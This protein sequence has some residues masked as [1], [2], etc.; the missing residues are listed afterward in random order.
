MF[1]QEIILTP[2]QCESIIDMNK[3]YTPSKVIRNSE[4]VVAL[5]RTSSES[6]VDT[7]EEIKSILLPKLSKYGVSDLPNSFNL[8]KYVG[9]E[10]KKHK[11]V[12]Y[13]PIQTND[14]KHY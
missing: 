2:S 5:G 14:I 4:V 1:N 6:K 12:G 11:D 7:S 8:L 3:G 9:T 10:F 13:T